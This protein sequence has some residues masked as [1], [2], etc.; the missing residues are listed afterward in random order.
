MDPGYAGSLARRQYS[1]TNTSWI[2]NNFENSQALC[3]LAS[4]SHPEDARR[5]AEPFLM[6]PPVDCPDV[7]SGLPA[8][9]TPDRGAQLPS[10]QRLCEAT[11]VPSPVLSLQDQVAHEPNIARFPMSRKMAASHRPDPAVVALLRAAIKARHLRRRGWLTVRKPPVFTAHTM[12]ICFG[13]GCGVPIMSALT[14]WDVSQDMVAGG[15]ELVFDTFGT[16]Q[17]D[18]WTLWP[19]YGDMI[20]KFRIED[21]P[22]STLNNLVYRTCILLAE[23]L[24]TKEGC[25]SQSA[26]TEYMQIGRRPKIALADIFLTHISFACYNGADYIVPTMRAKNRGNRGRH[27]IQ[28]R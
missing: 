22:G 17:L 23:W 13:D 18:L 12:E 4:A 11:G 20:D 6:L 9:I 5:L 25:P 1:D 8:D 26:R 15:E 2:T 3:Y 16:L 19:G 7:P 10:M 24:K 21:L 14:G 27:L 28:R